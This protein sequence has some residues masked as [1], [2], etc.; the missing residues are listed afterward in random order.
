MLTE[1]SPSVASLDFSLIKQ[2]TK[3]KIDKTQYQE[4]HTLFCNRVVDLIY[5]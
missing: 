5:F 1:G 2:K 4:E 3:K